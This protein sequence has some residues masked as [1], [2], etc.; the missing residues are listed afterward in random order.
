MICISKN[1]RISIWLAIYLIL[2][3]PWSVLFYTSLITS[4]LITS[5]STN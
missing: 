1:K 2:E 4:N 3:Q 5:K